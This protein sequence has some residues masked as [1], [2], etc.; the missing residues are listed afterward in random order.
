ME[1]KQLENVKND[2]FSEIKDESVTIEQLQSAGVSEQTIK[3]EIFLRK[4]FG[5]E[6]LFTDKKVTEVDESKKKI[7]K[8]DIAEIERMN[9]LMKYIENLKSSDFNKNLDVVVAKILSEQE[10]EEQ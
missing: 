4:K 7:T 9:N 6:I 3:S 8:I 1:N 10:N 2:F 5:D